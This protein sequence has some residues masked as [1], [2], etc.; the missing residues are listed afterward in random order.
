M[1]G[2]MNGCDM[3]PLSPVALLVSLYV[4]AVFICLLLT[5]KLTREKYM[6]LLQIA[7]FFKEHP[8]L[9]ICVKKDLSNLTITKSH[10]QIETRN[11]F[12]KI[13]TWNYMLSLCLCVLVQVW[14]APLINSINV[15]FTTL[16]HTWLITFSNLSYST[17][18]LCNSVKSIIFL[19][20]IVNIIFCVWWNVL[21]N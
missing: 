1:I 21:N 10:Y 3:V 17:T 13:K 12:L 6:K 2:Y 19:V 14:H 16:L 7:Q 5:P 8:K 4:L 9:W 15:V 18:L 11:K 20:H